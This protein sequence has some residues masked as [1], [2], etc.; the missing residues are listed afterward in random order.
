MRR[1]RLSLPDL[2]AV[3]VLVLIGL[4]TFLAIRRTLRGLPDF[5]FFYAAGRYV[6]QHRAL[7]GEGHV[8][9]LPWYLPALSR[10]FAVFALVPAGMAGVVWALLN[11][12]MLLVTLR[13]FGRHVSDAPREQWLASQFAPFM[14]T[15]P[16]WI[17]QFQLS[18]LTVFVLF[19][20]AG[21]LW[22]WESNRRTLA[23]CV[24]GVAILI[25][26]TPVVL[27]GWFLLKRQ[28][29]TFAAC[30]ATILVLGPVSDVLTFGPAKAA[31]YYNDWYRSAVVNGSHRSF[32]LNQVEVDHRNQASGVTLARLLH[33]VDARR[34]LWN[35][36]R[37]K[38]W[39]PSI[40]VNVANVPLSTVARL[41][42]LLLAAVGLLLL[43]GLRRPA[44]ALN[45]SQLRLEWALAML[46]MVWFMPVLR[47]YHYAWVYPLLA[48]L[49]NAQLC[50]EAGVSVRLAWTVAILWVLPM[51]MLVSR[52]LRC[53]GP[54]MWTMLLMGLLIGA[55]LVVSE[56]RSAGRTSAESPAKPG[57]DHV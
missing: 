52:E 55:A 21:S 46:A 40:F 30:V 24:L 6:L 19:L 35:D 48:M 41:H 27:L 20:C 50:R 8:G 10:F 23:G 36:P 14:L 18:Q 4:L 51:P 11:T 17:Y 49:C 2:I 28:W 43:Y 47:L 39:G 31:G 45:R 7:A 29:R 37:S 16:Y 3:L 15:F 57:A 32:M 25:K 12:G 26:T 38:H 9:S 42:T 5:E 22:L 53:L 34:H 54:T 1:Y 13:W 44:V 33:P 56:R